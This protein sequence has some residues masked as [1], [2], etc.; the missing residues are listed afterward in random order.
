MK[1]AF[2]FAGF[3]YG[4]LAMM[5]IAATCVPAQAAAATNFD[6]RALNDSDI[7]TFLPLVCTDPHANTGTDAGGADACQAIIGYP[8]SGNAMVSQTYN[9][10]L[11]SI[12]YGHLTNADATQAY[13]SYTADFESHADNFGGGILFQMGSNGWQLV[14]WY[15]AYSMDGC[16]QLRPDGQAQM[17][18]ETS[19][20]GMG[21]SDTTLLLTTLS[22][23]PGPDGYKP[24]WTTV[25]AGRD[26]RQTL[27]PNTDC[28]AGNTDQTNA[29]MLLNVTDLARASDHPSEIA[30]VQVQYIEPS[31]ITAYCSKSDL[32]DAP[33]TGQTIRIFW[34]GASIS[35]SPNNSYLASSP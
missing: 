32:T 16:L 4:L 26:D 19:Y 22:D 3:V 15:P 6:A 13:V 27:N 11:T 25:L 8:A 5:G 2:L 33:V 12:I 21:E 9:I 24:N 34:N 17:L 14:R 31:A 28:P 10:T 29:N 7:Q 23:R 18:C 1:N 20:E 30:T 35:L